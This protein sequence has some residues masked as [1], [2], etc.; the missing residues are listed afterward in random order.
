MGS[1]H[2]VTSAPWVWY[3]GLG[4]LS[5]TVFLVFVHHPWVQAGAQVSIYAVS[6]A[7]LARRWWR[8]RAPQPDA[9]LTLAV[10]AFGLYFCASILGALLPLLITLE[11]PVT[12]P[13][14]LDGLFLLSY[15]LLGLFLWRLGSRSAGVGSRDVIDMLIVVGGVAPLF[16]V[17]LIQPLLESGA[18]LPALI[19]Y[20]AYPVSVFG[21]VC[22]T[23]RLAFVARRRTMLHLLLTGWIVGELSADVVFLHAS[24]NGVY[25]YGQAWQALWI[26]SATCV[27]SL[28]LH[29]RTEVL[30]EGRTRRQGSGSRRLWVLAGCLA[31]PIVTIFYV[32]VVTGRDFGVLFTAV[33]SFLLVFLLCLRL[34]GLMVDNATQLRVQERMQRLSDDLVHQSKHD[35]LTGLGNRLLFAEHADRA[36][37]QPAFGGERAAAVL[38]LDLDDFKLVNDTFGHDAGD[39]VLVEVSRRLRGVSRSGGERV[40]RLGGDEFVFLVPQ[41]RLDDALDLAEQITAALSEPFD[42]GPREVRPVASI[43]VSIALNGQERNALL[44]EADLAMYAGKTRGS[45]PSVFD[46][47]LHRETLDRHQLERDL[48][49]AVARHE[50]RVL[51]QPLVHL[52]TREMVGVEALVRWQHPTRGMISPAEF[53]PLA[54]TNGAILDIGDWVL[55]ESLRQLLVWDMSCLEDRLHISVNVSPRQLNDPEFVGRAADMLLHSGIDP[56][57]VNLEI[58]EAAFGADAEGIIERLNELKLLGLTLA[59]D[60]FGTEYSSL[61]KLRR[62]PVDILK[63][64]KSFV[65]AIATDPAER[66]LAGA[67][68]NLATTLGKITVA[69]GIETEDQLA[70]LLSFA[71]KFGQG[72]LFARPLTADAISDLLDQARVKASSTS[73]MAAVANLGDDPLLV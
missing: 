19:T 36:L 71:V 55:K 35:P 57:R 31:A 45:S 10:V 50:M 47:A 38:L 48:R 66:A 65:D 60:D 42:L 24:V 62:I 8:T 34:S 64:D 11:A 69:E 16:W 28:A 53:I 41:V 73:E 51:Y 70:Q 23:V 3:L 17:F 30:L 52:A 58:T 39:R 12:A 18:P 20:L 72:Y 6:G 5:T 54:E 1:R 22:L 63:M 21:L 46:P 25:A 37:A 67:I 13:S 43:G 44:A 33:V 68:V 59:I 15:A 29:P 2:S 49:D 9:L 56:A 7:L 61:S 26:V 40:F 27:G 32:E 14:F 4:G